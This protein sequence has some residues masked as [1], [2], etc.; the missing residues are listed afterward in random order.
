MQPVREI[1]P[2]RITP[3]GSNNQLLYFTSTSLLAGDDAIVFLSERTGHP[4]I[5]YMN[6]KTGEERQLTFN[7]DGVLKSYVYFWGN[8]YKGLGKASV[9]LHAESGNIYYIQG[10]DI[11]C[12]DIEGNQRILAE[13]PDKQVTAFT[14][15]SSDGTLLC[16]PT[17]DARALEYDTPQDTSRYRPNYDID[18]RVRRE[19]LS[20]WLRVYDTRTGKEVLA[21]QV[22]RAWI[23]HVQF[24][25]VDNKKILYNHEWPSDCGIRRIWLWDGKKHIRM[26]TEGD[27]RSRE[28]WTCHE[29]WQ[30]SGNEIIYHGIYKNNVPYIGKMNA[31]GSNITEIPLPESYRKYGHFTVSNSGLLVSDGYYQEENEDSSGHGQ[32]IS[33]QKVDW[34]NRRIE[35]IPLCKSGSNWDSQDSHPHPIFNHGDTA[36]Y[37]TSNKEGYRA[38]YRI[39]LTGLKGLL[40]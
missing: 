3:A 35:W 26:R 20:S 32:W 11:C 36:V 28:D 29:M 31:D 14:H 12:V 21:E 16:V 27:G 18:E 38:V 39:D 24:N 33:F 23:T 13:L 17:T 40:G 15:V 5:F 22:P 34:E 37:F 30:R 19:N 2:A 4:N 6:L 25:P 8:E 10:R 9:C 7:E 1:K